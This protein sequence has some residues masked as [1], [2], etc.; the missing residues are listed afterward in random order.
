MKRQLAQK[1]IRFYNVNAIKLAAETGMGG[2]INTVMQA[3]FF[4][5]SA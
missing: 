5:L 2:R 1:K 3:A 4:K